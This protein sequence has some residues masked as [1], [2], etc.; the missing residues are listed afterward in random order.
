MGSLA[1]KAEVLIVVDF[2]MVRMVEAVEMAAMAETVAAEARL[3]MN[4]TRWNAHRFLL[5]LPVD[6]AMKLIRV[7]E[8]PVD[9]AEAV[10]MVETA[11]I[12]GYL[13]VL[14]GLRENRDAMDA[15]VQVATAG[16]STRGAVNSKAGRI[17][18]QT[19]SRICSRNPV[20][21]EGRNLGALL[22]AC[23]AH[24]SIRV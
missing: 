10:A 22:P 4:G 9:Q 21:F 14:V 2:A 17:G 6:I 1:E 24:E 16:G 20:A 11:P 7:L 23:V 5:G 3:N 18:S 13:G 19:N 15:K 12:V 8:V